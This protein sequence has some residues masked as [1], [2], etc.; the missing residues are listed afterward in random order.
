MLLA[1]LDNSLSILKRR[2]SN[3]PRELI[4]LV[5]MS[6]VP[7]WLEPNVFMTL[8][9][10]KEQA[11]SA[12]DLLQNLHL[13]TSVGPNQA[14][15]R[16]EARR[17]LINAII[18]GH[19]I[20]FIEI[21]RQM[22]TFCLSSLRNSRNEEQR[23]RW[24]RATMYHLVA[25]NEPDGWS[26]LARL[27]DDAVARGLKGTAKQ[28]LDPL[29]I[30]HPLLSH[31]DRTVL[32]YYKARLA[33]IEN[34][35]RRAK[36]FF[37]TVTNNSKSEILIGVAHRGLAQTMIMQ[38]DWSKGLHELYKSRNCL[39][40]AE[41]PYSL[42]LTWATEGHL[43]QEMSDFYGGLKK[44]E[45]RIFTDP[46]SFKQ[47]LLFW[48]LLA[49][50]HLA[51]RIQRLPFI[52]AGFNY[53]DWLTA[54]LLV[55][56]TN[57]YHHADHVLNKG[58]SPH[59]QFEIQTGLVGLYIQ[60]GMI[61]RAQQLLNRLDEW[62]YTQNSEYRKAHIKYWR[63]ELS[64]YLGNYAITKTLLQEIIFIFEKYRHSRYI[65]TIYRRLGETEYQA[66]QTQAAIEAYRVAATNYAKVGQI[67][68]QTA[69][70]D[71]ITN[72]IG[73]NFDNTTPLEYLARFSTNLAQRYRRLAYWTVLWVFLLTVLVFWL[74]G[75][76]IEGD[77]KLDLTS[78]V[79]VFY[80]L[81]WPLFAF[82]CFQII[83]QVLGLLA[84][85]RIPIDRLEHDARI[86]FIL[87]G[88]KL[89]AYDS[90]QEKAEHLRYEDILLLQDVTCLFRSHTL[91][92]FSY[93]RV[94]TL[95][96]EIQIPGHTIGY[97]NL[98][99]NLKRHLPNEICQTHIFQLLPFPP[100]SGVIVTILGGILYQLGFQLGADPVN[101]SNY[102]L[103]TEIS[104]IS[105]GAIVTTILYLP[106]IMLWNLLLHRRRLRQY[107]RMNSTPKAAPRTEKYLIVAAII[108]TLIAFLYLIIAI[109]FI[110]NPVP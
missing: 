45:S 69:L 94:V 89:T 4:Q 70:I 110:L 88:A 62:E 90:N 68:S 49:Y 63:A 50:H 67:L 36:C 79:F 106:P 44:V 99:R 107:L 21:N 40:Q 86:R 101:S 32:M 34:K 20:D 98:L 12:L 31:K 47:L 52:N 102:Y 77:L 41:D 95:T 38:Q 1:S 103:P 91:S 59:T 74:I 66:N 27:F 42:A 37:Q 48:P 23:F 58:E 108:W 26:W 22:A 16:P 2:L 92:L 25:A 35:H 28:V 82:W 29:R 10:S 60:L 33:L 78:I 55:A 11:N 6:C 64:F 104:G 18:R 80:L 97:K 96:T 43:F 9:S 81:V 7:L 105:L 65:A 15:I 3:L 8:Y 109:L 61:Q 75:F 14:I 56:A 39:S 87:N 73:R 17:Y 71:K 19:V 30:L 53:Q 84:A 76:R 72:I 5:Y 24:A 83:Y 46:I 93:T 57:A 100:L 54:R 51:I 85:F 13:I